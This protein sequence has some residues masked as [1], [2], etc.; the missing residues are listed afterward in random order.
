MK[1]S[2]TR[3]D[4]EEN[5][6]KTP[7]VS[8]SPLA[9]VLCNG[10]PGNLEAGNVNT[11]FRRYAGKITSIC[12]TF[13]GKAD[14][15]SKT[16]F[17]EVG[18]HYD[19]DV[20]I[21]RA[22]TRDPDLR[23][24]L[25]V[26]APSVIVTEMHG[27]MRKYTNYNAELQYIDLCCTLFIL[28]CGVAKYVNTGMLSAQDLLC[29]QQP[30]I[31]ALSMENRNAGVVDN[32]V[33]VPQ[34]VSFQNCPAAFG[35]IQSAVN[36]SG[37]RV[38]TDVAMLNADMQVIVPV[39]TN[40]LLA[41]G[42]VHAIRLIYGMYVAMGMEDLAALAIT[43]GIH[44]FV[45]VVGHS[46]EGGFNRDWIR[47]LGFAPSRGCVSASFIDEAIS[48]PTV[49]TRS[50]S[51]YTT[52]V[53]SIALATAAAVACAA[54]VVTY[55]G[56]SYP[57][58]FVSDVAAAG[59]DG[60]AHDAALNEDVIS[61]A[62]EIS[63][64]CCDFAVSYV[65][66]LLWWFGSKKAA[67]DR[68]S[69]AVVNMIQHC[70]RD[71]RGGHLNQKTIA[72]W[73]WIEPT[74]IYPVRRDT[75]AGLAD[76]GALAGTRVSYETGMFEKV[77]KVA[78]YGVFSDWVVSWRG[79]RTNY[80]I[81]H[82]Y[83]HVRDG[84]ATIVPVQF[85]AENMINKGGVNTAVAARDGYNGLE[86]YVWNRG[87]SPIA[88]PAECLYAGEAM[89]IRIRHE[90]ERRNGPGYR[91]EHCPLADEIVTGKVKIIATSPCRM[92]EDGGFEAW[93]RNRRCNVSRG[94]Y[95]LMQASNRISSSTVV[96]YVEMVS[97]NVEPV[98]VTHNEV[99]VTGDSENANVNLD[100]R[101]DPVNLVGPAAEPV[102][103]QAPARLRHEQGGRQVV[104]QRIQADAHA[105]N[106][107]AQQDQQRQVNVEAQVHDP[108]LL[109]GGG[110]AVLQAQGLVA[111]GV[112]PEGGGQGVV[113]APNAA[114]EV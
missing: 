15:S 12:P 16:V 10:R 79:M 26:C 92:A 35:A 67:S 80:L 5:T 52:W 61:V 91:E 78:E 41:D 106:I 33:F 7:S 75:S 54:P 66:E 81:T 43:K 96:G 31:V 36:G 38:I 82:L 39:Y 8:E 77:A 47:S 74:T 71:Y 97:M 50:H 100:P 111:E 109:A 105:R 94:G 18:R 114:H 27:I 24:S 108:G 83:S 3:S 22:V 37:S 48:L 86:A 2:D 89:A 103:L 32:G 76:Y 45:T 99:P 29:G 25:P 53:D 85:V 17:Y 21:E 34:V 9:G 113:L 69:G 49:N 63:S 87:Q 84:L 60:G 68:A 62:N 64:H 11:R 56:R 102:W 1:K 6:S 58:V 19:N 88:H 65:N 30:S 23:L 14:T 93:A 73:F 57:Q 112:I 20:T 51:S 95:A 101:L 90:T 44:S 46:N 42:C 70:C 59:N 104:A 40:A 98:F 55:K 110:E 4:S 28:A 13:R 72:P 107:L